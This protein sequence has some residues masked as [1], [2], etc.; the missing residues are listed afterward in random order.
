MEWFLYDRNLRHERVKVIVVIFFS[1]LM[2]VYFYKLSLYHRWL[3]R[4]SDKLSYL[5]LLTENAQLSNFLH[6]GQLVKDSI[7][8]SLNSIFW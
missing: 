6:Q 4:Q 3:Q 1:F 2:I 7:P 8:I 5:I